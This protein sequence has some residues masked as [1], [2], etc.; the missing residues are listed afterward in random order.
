MSTYTTAT[1]PVNLS[2]TLKALEEMQ[3]RLA[4][5]QRRLQDAARRLFPRNDLCDGCEQF[6]ADCLTVQEFDQMGQAFTYCAACRKE[7]A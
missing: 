1:S 3:A 5:L 4:D 6:A 7:V 2:R